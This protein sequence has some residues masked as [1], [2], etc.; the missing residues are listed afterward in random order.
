MNKQEEINKLFWRYK[1]LISSKDIWSEQVTNSIL[2]N[3]WEIEDILY[4][5]RERGK[6]PWNI[7]S[8]FESLNLTKILWEKAQNIDWYIDEIL[9]RMNDILSS[10]ESIEE[11]LEKLGV[12]HKKLKATIIPTDWTIRWN[13]SWN[14]KWDFEKKEL[15][16]SKISE[17][18]W[19]LHK[20]D[21]YTD[22]YIIYSW[23]NEKNMM[24]KTSYII[25][26]IPKLNRSIAVC[27]EYWEA[28]FITRWARHPNIYLKNLKTQLV[29]DHGAYRLINNEDWLSKLE[30]LLFHDWET[31]E[32]ISIK[33]DE[34][35]LSPEKKKEKLIQSSEAIEYIIDKYSPEYLMSLSS[36][37]SKKK[38][39]NFE[40]EDKKIKKETWL[41][42]WELGWILDIKENNWEYIWDKI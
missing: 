18:I 23:E 36:K 32:K 21:I 38:D 35:K 42:F 22:D 14:W 39:N 20:N 4:S 31:K 17:I 8:R 9:W 24:R 28:T 25:I 7:R 6:I 41:S 34:R 12:L 29:S 33:E 19:L 1:K 37:K 15:D 26:M 16:Y 5:K 10:E 3:L 11:K 40:E 13:I 30:E 27:D 2:D